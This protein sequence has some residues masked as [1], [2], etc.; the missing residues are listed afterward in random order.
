MAKLLSKFF[1]E[2]TWKPKVGDTE[3]ST[4]DTTNKEHGKGR[5]IIIKNKVMSGEYS[6][7]SIFIALSVVIE[8]PE[9]LDCLI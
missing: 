1:A 3:L 7:P 6:T 2:E 4:L 8:D 9:F 5:L